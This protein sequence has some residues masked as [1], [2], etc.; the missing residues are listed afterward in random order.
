MERNRENWVF[1]P[2]KAYEFIRDNEKYREELIAKIKEKDAK[3]KKASAPAAGVGKVVAST[4]VLA[5]SLPFMACM[6]ATAAAVTTSMVLVLAFVTVAAVIAVGAILAKWNKALHRE[7]KSKVNAEFV[8]ITQKP[9]YRIVSRK[10]LKPGYRSVNSPGADVFSGYAMTLT[11]YYSPRGNEVSASEAFETI[12]ELIKDYS[13]SH[14]ESV[15]IEQVS[16]RLSYDEGGG[17]DH[18]SDSIPVAKQ[19][20]EAIEE[21]AGTNPEL[22]YQA[23]LA[24]IKSCWTEI[25]IW[26]IGM[27]AKSGRKEAIAPLKQI[28]EEHSSGRDIYGLYKAA[29]DALIKIEGRSSNSGA[30]V[31]TALAVFFALSNIAWAPVAATATTVSPVVA[32][33]SVLAIAVVV[34]LVLAI[35][36]KLLAAQRSLYTINREKR[37]R[38]GYREV[39]GLTGADVCGGVG[40]MVSFTPDTYYS[41]DG[42]EVTASE[43]FVIIESLVKIEPSRFYSDDDY[44]RAIK[45]VSPRL[46]Y[47]EGGGSDHYSEYI[48]VAEDAAKAIEEMAGN[49]PGLQYQA[50]LAGIESCWSEINIWGIK[51]LAKSG[52]KEAIVPLRG[53]LN[54]PERVKV[55]AQGALIRI[56]GKS[57]NNT[58]V[59]STLLVAFFALSNIAWTPVA[60]ATSSPVVVLAI[61]VAVGI[62]I[63]GW[64]ILKGKK[65]K[66]NVQDEISA[67]KIMQL[68]GKQRKIGF[69]TPGLLG[70][71]KTYWAGR[72]KVNQVA[73]RDPKNYGKGVKFVEPESKQDAVNKFG[74]TEGSIIWRRHLDRQDMGRKI[75]LVDGRQKCNLCPQFMPAIEEALEWRN[76]L[77]VMQPFPITDN[78]HFVLINKEHRPQIGIDESEIGDFIDFTA[79][80]KGARLIAN[81]IGASIYYHMHGQGLFEKAAIEDEKISVLAQSG[82]V[83]IGELP[84]WPCISFV[85]EAKVEDKEALK[86]E[87]VSFVRLMNGIDLLKDEKPEFKVGKSGVDL[88]FA[89]DGTSTIR[90][91]VIP[92]S[93]WYPLTTWKDIPCGVPDVTGLITIISDEDA[94]EIRNVSAQEAA[95]KADQMV[96]EIGHT[97]KVLL[98]PAYDYL[99]SRKGALVAGRLRVTDVSSLEHA[100]T[101]IW[102]TTTA[103][104]ASGKVPGKVTRQGPEY[105]VASIIPLSE[106]PGELVACLSKIMEELKRDFPELT[107]TPVELLHSTLFDIVPSSSDESAANL[108]LE[109][110]RKFTDTVSSSVK[111]GQIKYSIRGLSLGPD[112][113][114]FAQG[115]VADEK[116]FG[117]R[118]SL[119]KTFPDSRRE[120]PF[121]HITLARITTPIS[122]ERFKALYDRI[123]QSRNTELGAIAITRFAL[124]QRYDNFGF[125]RSNEVAIDLPKETIYNYCELKEGKVIIRTGALDLSKVKGVVVKVLLSGVC[126]A[127][128]KEAS[129]SRTVLEDRGPLFGHELV[130]E[131]VAVGEDSQFKIGDRVVFNPNIT[132]NRTTGFAEYFVVEEKTGEALIRIPRDLPLEVAVFAEPFSCVLHSVK[133]LLDVLQLQDFQNKKIAIVGAGNAG[134]FYAWLIKYFK[135]DPVLFN[136]ADGRLEFI[137]E[138]EL[139]DAN[140]C[141]LLDEAKRFNSEFDIVILTPTIVTQ[142]IINTGIGM[143]KSGGDIHLYGGTKE[144]DKFKEIEIDKIRK[145]K[146]GIGTASIS[147][148]T[149]NFTGV[150]GTYAIDFEETLT[151]FQ[152]NECARL[153]P[154]IISKVI[155]LKDL[156]FIV[157]DMVTGTKDYPGK[158][159]VNCEEKVPG[160]R[161][162]PLEPLAKGFSIKFG[163]SGW[164]GQLG[165]DFVSPNVRRTV[166]G[167]A[168]YYHYEKA[169]QA[170]SGKT[171]ERDTILIG[172]DPRRGNPGF[173]VEAASILAANNIKVEIVLEEPT[174]TPVL[175]YRAN[176]SKHIF[177]VI[178]LS[179][180]HN[181][182]IDDGLKFSPYHGGAAKKAITDKVQEFANKAQ[183]YMTANYDEAK[184][185]E[186][187]TEISLKQA[188]QEYVH[189]YIIK[190]LKAIGAWN[191]ICNYVRAHPDFSLFLDPMQGTA[192]KYMEAIFDELAKD[193]GRVFFIVLHKNN[194]DPEFKEVNGAP[195]PTL[196]NSARELIDLIKADPNRFGLGTD[197]DADRFGTVDF[198][199][200]L[201]TANDL[202]PLLAY[203]LNKALGFKGAVGKTVATSNLVNV[204]ASH[205]GLEIIEVPVGFK[206]FAEL[207]VDAGKE[208]LV[209]GEESAH[210]AIGPFM[211]SW[212]DGI[213]I[214]LAAL[215]IVSRTGKSLG[216]YKKQIEE[217]V[218]KA[219]VITTTT[220]RGKES[221]KAGV[222]ELVSETNEALARGVA[223]TE[224]PVA[225]RVKA[226]W[227]IPV[228]DLIT[229]DGVKIV[230]ATGDWIM[231]R[232][233]GTEPAVKL[234]V[235][236]T[237][238]ERMD[239]LAGVGKFLLDEY[240]KIAAAKSQPAN[241]P[242]R[243]PANSRQEIEEKY[244]TSRVLTDITV[245][246][247][248]LNQLGAFFENHQE[249]LGERLAQLENLF[250]R[251]PPELSNWRLVIT[252]D[253]NLTNAMVAACSIDARTVFIHPY[254]FELPE[255]KQLE[256]LYHELI[257]HILK[258]VRDDIDAM[259]DTE[260]LFPNKEQN[261]NKPLPRIEVVRKFNPVEVKLVVFDW[262]DTTMQALLWRD[263][264]KGIARNILGRDVD[265]LELPA[266]GGV[267]GTIRWAIAKA[268]AEGKAGLKSEYDYAIQYVKD[269]TPL[270]KDEARVVGGVK[271]LIALFRKQLGVSVIAISRAYIQEKLMQAEVLGLSDAF[272]SII[273]LIPGDTKD[274]D[275]AKLKTKEMGN[276]KKRLALRDGQIIKLGDR[277]ADMQAANNVGA[278][279]IGIAKDA[280]TRQRLID[281][282][283]HVIINGNF[284]GIQDEIIKLFSFGGSLTE[285]T[286]RCVA[287]LEDM[288]RIETVRPFAQVQRK[289]IVFDW[290][291][292]TV[293]DLSAKQIV[294]KIITDI[295]GY[296]ANEKDI[297]I[298]AGLP[299]VLR[300]AM[301]KAQAEGRTGLRSEQEYVDEYIKE[302]KILVETQG[303]LIPGVKELI[304]L[305]KRQSEVKVI[306]LSR[307]YIQ[308]IRLMAEA[309]GLT[310]LFDDL[311][312]VH[313][314]G[315]E[316][317]TRI[318]PFKT[319]VMSSMKAELGLVDGQIVKFGDRVSDMQAAVNVGAVAIGIAKDAL[320]RQRLIDAGANI[321]INGNFENA[322]DEILRLL[323]FVM[324]ENNETIE[325]TFDKADIGRS[326]F[327]L[328]LSAQLSSA[329]RI[330]EIAVQ[331]YDLL[332]NNFAQRIII[333][334]CNAFYFEEVVKAFVRIDNQGMIGERVVLLFGKCL[335]F[336]RAESSVAYLDV[337][338]RLRWDLKELP[339]LPQEALFI[340]MNIGSTYT[341]CVIV[342]GSETVA[343][344]SKILWNPERGNK[345]WARPTTYVQFVEGIEQFVRSTAA[346]AGI[347]LK[348]IQGIGIGTVGMMKD[349]RILTRANVTRSLSNE[350]FAKVTNLKD[351]LSS[352][353]GGIAV[354]VEMDGKVAALGER[355]ATGLTNALVVKLGTAMAGKMIDANGNI[356]DNF[357]E[358]RQIIINR[359]PKAHVNPHTGVRGTLRSYGTAEALEVIAEEILGRKLSYH[360]IMD[361]LKSSTPEDA[362]KIITLSGQYLA[363]GFVKLARI[364]GNEQVIISGKNLEGKAGK[365]IIQAIEQTLLEE[366]AG[367]NLKISLSDT[368]IDYAVALGGAYMAAFEYLQSRKY[369]FLGKLYALN[370]DDI[371]EAQAIEEELG[372]EVL[373]RPGIYK[374]LM[375]RFTGCQFD[376]NKVIFLQNQ[377]IKENY[378]A[379]LR[380]NLTSI[381]RQAL[382]QTAREIGSSDL[383]RVIK[384]IR[385][386]NLRL[387]LAQ[388]KQ[389]INLDL[390]KLYWGKD[391]A[392]VYRYAEALRDLF[393]AVERNE[394]WYFANGRIN[395]PK[396]NTEIYCMI[397][398]LPQLAPF[399]NSLRILWDK[400]FGVSRYIRRVEELEVA[401]GLRVKNDAYKLHFF[402][403]NEYSNGK[404]S[405]HPYADFV[406]PQR[407]AVSLKTGI[408]QLR[409]KILA[410]LKVQPSTPVIVRIDGRPG[411]R[412]SHSITLLKE[413]LSGSVAKSEIAL[414]EVNNYKRPDLWYYDSQA[415]YR[416]YE[417]LISSGKYKV[418]LVE[419]TVIELYVPEAL[420]KGDFTVYIES[421]ERRRMEYLLNGDD[422]ERLEY[423]LQYHP[424]HNIIMRYR[425][426]TIRKAADFVIDTY[427]IPEE[428]ITN[429][430]TEGND[431][432]ESLTAKLA[433]GIYFSSVDEKILTGQQVIFQALNWM[434]ARGLIKNQDNL[435]L[436]IFTPK[437]FI[438]GYDDRGIG[439]SERIFSDVTLSDKERQSV[440]LF[441]LFLLLKRNE[442]LINGLNGE[443]IKRGMCQ[444]IASLHHLFTDLL[445]LLL[446]YNTSGATLDAFVSGVKKLG[447]SVE[448]VEAFLR[449]VDES[450]TN[451]SE[452]NKL[453]LIFAY[454]ARYHQ[455]FNKSLYL[456]N[457][458]SVNVADLVHK[459]TNAITLKPTLPVSRHYPFSVTTDKYDT[460][461]PV[462]LKLIIKDA[463]I[464]MSINE[465]NLSSTQED[466]LSSWFD[467]LR[468][469]LAH[470]PP[471]K[472]ELIVYIT[473]ETSPTA[474]GRIIAEYIYS[475]SDKANVVRLH[476]VIVNTNLESKLCSYFFTSL[477]FD[478]IQSHHL[479]GLDQRSGDAY[480]QRF[481]LS[482]AH[483]LRAITD[484]MEKLAAVGIVPDAQWREALLDLCDK[485]RLQPE[486]NI[487]EFY[488]AVDQKTG[489]RFTFATVSVDPDDINATI[490]EK[491]RV[492]VKNIAR[493]ITEK[494]RKPLFAMSILGLPT[495]PEVDIKN[496]QDFLRAMV[497]STDAIGI[498]IA[499]GHTV[500]NPNVIYTMALVEVIPASEVP[501]LIDEPSASSNNGEITFLEDKLIA[502]HRTQG[503]AAK[504]PPD[505]LDQILSCAISKLPLNNF[506]QVHVKDDVIL[507]RL[508]EE[509]SI[510]FTVD[511]IKPIVNSARLYSRIAIDHAAS[512]LYAK[513]ILPKGTVDVMFTPSLIE[514]GVVS[515]IVNAGKSEIARISSEHLGIYSVPNQDLFY[516]ALMYGI[517]HH[518]KYLSNSTVN[519]GDWIILTKPIGSGV[520]SSFAV[521]KAL[522][523]TAK[524]AD[525]YRHMLSCLVEPSDKASEVLRETGASASTDV[526]GFSLIGH[527]NEMLEPR[528]M[529]AQLW[530]N[531]VPLYPGSEE[532]YL[533]AYPC[534]VNR[535]RHYFSH[536]V[537]LDVSVDDSAHEAPVS[538]LYDAQTSGGLL[539][540]APEALAR[541]ILELLDAKDI[542]AAIIGQITERGEHPIYVQDEPGFDVPRIAHR[543]EKV[544]QRNVQ[545]EANF[546]RI[547]DDMLKH[548]AEII[549]SGARIFDIDGTLFELSDQRATL[550]DGK[551]TELRDDICFSL[552]RKERN[553]F[554][555][556]QSFGM[557]HPRVVAPIYKRL[558]ELGR[559]E[560]IKNCFLY[561][562]L[563]AMKFEF[564][565]RGQAKLDE[566]HNAAYSISADDLEI[567][568]NALIQIVNNKFSSEALNISEEVR[569][570]LLNQYRSQMGKDGA[571]AARYKHIGFTMPWMSGEKHKL[572]VFGYDLDSHGRRLLE[573]RLIDD[574]MAKEKL[575]L[576]AEINVPWMDL[577]DGIELT[578]TPIP[579]GVGRA[580]VRMAI[581]NKIKAA[582]GPNA[583]KYD[584]IP[585][586]TTSININRKGVNKA[587]AI[588]SFIQSH[589]LDRRLVY[590]FGDEYFPGGGDASALGVKGINHLAVCAYGREVNA[591]RIGDDYRAIGRLLR[592]IRPNTYH[593]NISQAI[594]QNWATYQ[595]KAFKAEGLTLLDAEQ[596]ADQEF[597]VMQDLLEN[598]SRL[599]VYVPFAWDLVFTANLGLTAGQVAAVNLKQK[600]SVSYPENTIFIHPHFINIA[601]SLQLEVLY[602]ELVA[603]LAYGIEDEDL[604]G[605]YHVADLGGVK[606][607][608]ILQSALRHK[609]S[610]K[611]DYPRTS[612][613][614][615]IDHV[616]RYFPGT[617]KM[618]AAYIDM[619]LHDKAFTVDSYAQFAGVSLKVAEAT[620]EY[621]ASLDREEDMHLR[622]A[623]IDRVKEADPVMDATG[624]KEIGRNGRITYRR[625]FID[626]NIFRSYD[627]R[628]VAIPELILRA[629]TQSISQNITD[630]VQY[631]MTRVVV[632]LM[633]EVESK[634]RKI[635]RAK[636][637]N[638]SYF[639]DVHRRQMEISSRFG[640]KRSSNY[641]A[642]VARDDRLASGPMNEYT[643]RS[644]EELNVQRMGLGLQPITHIPVLSEAAIRAFLTSGIDVVDIGQTST[645]ALLEA[646]PLL[647]ANIA[648]MNT[649][650][651]SE[652]RW[653][654]DK[655]LIGPDKDL[656][657]EHALE[658]ALPLKGTFV[659]RY[660]AN[661]RKFTKLNNNRYGSLT[662]LPAVN[663][664]TV[665]DQ[666]INDIKTTLL[667]TK[668][669]EWEEEVFKDNVDRDCM[670]ALQPYRVLEALD[671]FKP[672]K[673]PQLYLGLKAVVDCGNGMAKKYV[674]GQLERMGMDITYLNADPNGT[675]PA[676]LPDPTLDENRLQ[677]RAKMQEV[678]ADIG[679]GY[680]TDVDRIFVVLRLRKVESEGW[681]F[682]YVELAG[683]FIGAVT[684]KE[685][686]QQ[687][688][689]AVIIGD[690]RN[691]FC[692]KEIVEGLGCVYHL[693]FAGYTNIIQ[694]LKD[695]SG[696]YGFEKTGHFFPR[697][698]FKFDDSVYIS[699]LFASVFCKNKKSAE[700]TLEGI[701]FYAETP[702]LRVPCTSLE[703][704]RKTFREIQDDLMSIVGV[705][706][707]RPVPGLKNDSDMAIENPERG[708]F[709]VVRVSGTEPQM[710]SVG[711]VHEEIDIYLPHQEQEVKRNDVLRQLL[712][713]GVYR[714]M[715]M[716]DKVNFLGFDFYYSQVA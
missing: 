635:L 134:L 360:E 428:N 272:D 636:G 509:R 411:N 238:K 72:H 302:F 678:D 625:I 187:I 560:A 446:E 146:L 432:L 70:Q 384:A 373:P 645:P 292:T 593:L 81:G 76:W 550:D 346:D 205:L 226:I 248:S 400:L 67:E 136:I 49:N 595:D 441:N 715:M 322:Q 503:C 608:L 674:E 670:S 479:L 607:N 338:E 683:D 213:A 303:K 290:D 151:L 640:I 435:K 372:V 662:R 51:M 544:L 647:S 58:A 189:E 140:K 165:E 526:T 122:P 350:D 339:N 416:D 335:E 543:A 637:A 699:G 395:K 562:S 424:Y 142:D 706:G 420:P 656:P 531:R 234:Y 11:S 215:W 48:A 92:R 295:L 410:K 224:A 12:E 672:V 429:V 351:D 493:V 162:L 202:I 203:F 304:A 126:R 344:A 630:K 149:I 356:T 613:A 451:T 515:K 533:M 407:K 15:A 54:K 703:D 227:N 490:A 257:S 445:P 247:F 475:E 519:K 211:K 37:L 57:N 585:G 280:G 110:V 281:A 358:I 710:T 489:L 649:A 320:S 206:W 415:F 56:E 258:G 586:G 382:W 196:I 218:G 541:K 145:E 104:V 537:G 96:A 97:D 696:V 378:F 589:K 271:E 69:I 453:K 368:D 364:F 612:S 567:I 129:G 363:R 433:C 293:E 532:F 403:R 404:F 623:G 496:L 95:R 517:C 125:K 153:I 524:E 128:I 207:A 273:C 85:F 576:T 259:K 714:L 536:L 2:Y 521:L 315:K 658:N 306:A 190:T 539:I 309:F 114:I 511:I 700:K 230:F 184:A 460:F 119:D 476:P 628:G 55:T 183:Y 676:H 443:P 622:Y 474:Q 308:K 65:Q 152:S 641:L 118:D 651:H 120:T 570:R 466:R 371:K 650:S 325:V 112:G 692:V 107:I 26:G 679:F 643:L 691:N 13:G 80:V 654:G 577:R 619:I 689:G 602:H 697:W 14:S 458:K 294:K 357:E 115:H 82:A 604:A 336:E 300:W 542:D 337:P 456:V 22:Q 321:I 77:V 282:G 507:Y 111:A 17:S 391:H 209:A 495:S 369:A 156:P 8:S 546:S 313:P 168:D 702:D 554:L 666:M 701:K 195:N 525:A 556:A 68:S 413:G 447:A 624:K 614:M 379:H 660:E 563:G 418:I 29:N 427:L 123:A 199:G 60:G 659:I 397:L 285:E 182:A 399:Y 686:A 333:S 709:A 580:E 44:R 642:V 223:K 508:D 547:S 237:N 398:P 421:I 494:N 713:T 192:V 86:K 707:F 549:S 442:I 629:D 312:C 255:T 45:E 163:T 173:A 154:K 31:T 88:F 135:G 43:S 618:K 582:L 638:E 548:G 194:R 265:D 34:I 504:Y 633:V 53:M 331:I 568:R 276:L 478:E 133:G 598:L 341:R 270:V 64:Y 323:G 208:F 518:D 279:A 552:M 246:N 434:Q 572:F 661:Q 609:I 690:E 71:I 352:R 222:A 249:I 283:A 289:L 332:V 243:V 254:F 288:P 216:A 30:V 130:G 139:F 385:E 366:F 484:N 101:S 528:K 296:A 477:L 116:V 417:A 18:Y 462:K 100:Y 263:T 497:E 274:I 103:M 648:C 4:A 558:V 160:S 573:P 191:D 121:L 669:A 652:V 175:A 102:D 98:K 74:K 687:F 79:L 597:E 486:Y 538:I 46:D 267:P 657:L 491:A 124:L 361:L 354:S 1:A 655:F 200:D 137:K 345:D 9:L 605:S 488:G 233:S 90:V 220:V 575:K 235:E 236:V 169:E 414:I 694:K 109:H 171:D 108:N 59:I 193:C 704:M 159:A 232:P 105:G 698:D 540:T 389:S 467:I 449:L 50:G 277:V 599:H 565:E 178:N 21:M 653:A 73:Y 144:N 5:L 201:I 514:K 286:K 353:L 534:S 185:N 388:I 91:Y 574:Q 155:S 594:Q 520:V 617:Q 439:L 461:A 505:K 19:A 492:F 639:A 52:F 84:N 671:K 252:T 157:D 39:P 677:L 693:G 631:Y 261:N 117:L 172:F 470:A 269:L 695:R 177:G 611:E 468:P 374:L 217:E 377:L 314:E 616:N 487:R 553:V 94:A 610:S 262:D 600:A 436:N 376:I 708:M 242:L 75:K 578:I 401:L 590:H 523:L 716:S 327:E 256:I 231:L 555:T 529:G 465:G 35:R 502:T 268:Q 437:N 500:D 498:P 512:D 127:D 27:L 301:A 588:E 644:L 214:S 409:D 444:E 405:I 452:A 113:G 221:I 430:S 601:R 688:P 307:A 603:H 535:N 402:R 324:P 667:C 587:S 138:R 326:T 158:V 681:P 33:V 592:K 210:V 362:K 422:K 38:D 164:R 23:G 450:K 219:F 47:Y 499:G 459:I 380:D 166:Q 448:Q 316:A 564:N 229:I 348:Q 20:A 406:M 319:K 557:Q 606:Y 197:G 342:K 527:L 28:Q 264:A 260:E 664:A 365:I 627:I 367:I 396:L 347:D 591:L 170:K 340:G 579:E 240:G 481:L 390:D 148:K 99:D 581:I 569:I 469:Y 472:E 147:G 438:A 6:P 78:H 298:P 3:S 482:Q 370:E 663:G 463:W 25:E 620:L 16:S 426:D 41:P 412:K 284:E 266:D 317:D 545:V 668:I 32:L 561:T 186:Y 457:L 583:D 42:R 408:H 522:D 551:Y 174:P 62:S 665:I 161:I 167:V 632:S 712:L 188:I 225:N 131:V 241:Y 330:E 506:G 571:F 245:S 310:D 375:H 204:V 328:E 198:G 634:Q 584:M 425:T 464:K 180:S 253:L 10:Q 251:G 318:E 93:H 705:Q 516:G 480:T 355:F 626:P 329:E 212:D 278:L 181:P 311:I 179:A 501:V 87:V 386:K 24:G 684:C 297:P 393:A 711:Q 291:G 334:G 66:N 176:N 63:F 675:F 596:N 566:E 132:K 89:N 141:L 287:G 392:L 343:K 106:F 394:G 471:E 387:A 431:S 239:G 530:L 349:G 615:F 510:A 381:G 483:I 680:D 559:P 454:L 682:H 359:S 440:V 513:G 383:L 419:G 621:F 83:T 685:I 275:I 673:L 228:V 305:F 455:N 646:L 143:V 250:G 244:G 61:L 423:F 7:P 40:Y 36:N 473:P 150:Y 299:G 485:A